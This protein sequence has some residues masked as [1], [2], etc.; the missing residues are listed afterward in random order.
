MKMRKAIEAI[1]EHG[2]LT[3]LQRL[4]LSEHQHVWLM[5]LSEETSTQDVARLAAQSPSFQFLAN[6]EENLYSPQDGQPV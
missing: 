5:I 4:S 2:H 1:F 3:P 6:P